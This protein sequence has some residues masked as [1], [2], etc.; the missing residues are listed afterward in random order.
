MLLLEKKVKCPLCGAKN[1]MR[2]P[3]CTIC[4]RPLENDPLPSQAVYQ[5][6]LWSTKIA[7]KS[8]RRSTNPLA[9]LGAVVVVAALM[10][11]FVLGFG[12]SW[13]HVAEPVAKGSQWKVYRGQPDYL[14]DLPGEPMVTTVPTMGT[15]LTVASVWVDGNWNPVRD[16]RTRSAGGLDE[17]RRNVTAGVMTASG[18]APAD[19]GAS[20]TAMV[21]SLVNGA[22]L[23][24]GGVSSVQNPDIG[25][26]FTLATTFTGW[27]EESNRGSVRAT[28]VVLDGRVYVAASF[29][30]NGDD[31][32]LHERLVENLTPGPH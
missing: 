2:A 4:T 30:L 23:A 11:Y 3:R 19:P 32:G 17:A 9:V 10:N 13:A 5:E 20:L 25:E 7:S 16:A 12:P 14:V 21:T 18:A 28:A 1:A 27:P 15:S 31:A 26:Q 24:P 8:V 29:V 22:E 6:A